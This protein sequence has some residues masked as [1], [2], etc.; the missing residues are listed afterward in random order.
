MGLSSAEPPRSR[1]GSSR[2]DPLPV[3]RAQGAPVAGAGEYELVAAAKTRLQ[4]G[5]HRT[6]QDAQ[7]RLRDRPEDPH[8]DAS[9]SHAKISMGRKIVHGRTE[10]RIALDNRLAHAPTHRAV[11]HGVVP[12]DTHDDPD[13]PRPDS[14]RVQPIEH[15]RQRLAHRRP[16]RGVI[17]QPMATVRPGRTSPSIASTSFPDTPPPAGERAG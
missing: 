17:H 12:A 10:A 14:D 1:A 8:G 4:M 9:R 6:D 7:V 13:I 11:T 15:D 3:Q 16:A 2:A 5:Q